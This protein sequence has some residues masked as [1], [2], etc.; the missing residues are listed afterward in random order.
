VAKRNPDYWEKGLP[1][2]DQVE[3]IMVANDDA[4]VNGVRTR[5]LDMIEFVPWKDI[6]VL[7]RERGLEVQVAGGAFMNLWFNAK[8]KPFDD[9]RV[10]QAVSYAIDREAVSAAAFLLDPLV[11]SADPPEAWW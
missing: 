1:Y 10:R 7:K 5:A 9:P 11:R 4:R 2:L 8:K 6:D 3:L